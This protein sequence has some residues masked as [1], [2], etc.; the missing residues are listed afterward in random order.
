[1]WFQIF[2]L[3]AS[4]FISAALAPKPQQPKA[5]SLSDFD[6]PQ[7]SEDTPQAMIFGDVWISD[8][9]VLGLGNFRVTEIRR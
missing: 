5:A 1:M 8:W 4:Y 6:F 9:M 2:I 3:V 7:S